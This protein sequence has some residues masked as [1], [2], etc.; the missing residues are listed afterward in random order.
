MVKKTRIGGSN[1]P[2]PTMKQLKELREE[3]GGQTRL[4]W[5]ENYWDGPLTGVM[6][7]EGEKCWFETYEDDF[8]ERPLT[9]E[10]IKDW[11]DFLKIPVEEVDEEDKIDYE[12][13]RRYNV[14]RIPKETMEAIEYN[15]NLFRKYVGTH[16]DYDENGLRHHNLADY[17][18]HH[19]YYNNRELHKKWEK[20]LDKWE[21]IDKFEW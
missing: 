4:L 21:L 9:E 7:W 12:P 5:H 19:K 3:N 6:L 8:V 10:E 15:H 20:D 16:T 1:P 13:Y 17:N 2:R 11:A 18:E 14:Y